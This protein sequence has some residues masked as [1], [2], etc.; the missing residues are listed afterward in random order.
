VWHRVACQKTARSFRRT[1]LVSD[2]NLGRRIKRRNRSS[3]GSR[4]LVLGREIS[5]QTRINSKRQTQLALAD[6]T[7]GV[8]SY[9]VWGMLGWQD[10]KQRYR[11]SV[12]GPFWLT[13]S[14]A[15]MVVALG[16]VYAAIFRMPLQ[17]YLPFLAI[18]L[19]LWTL[20]SSVITEGCQAFIS[21]EAMI[22]QMRLPFTAH[23]CRTVWRNIIIM[24]HNF[25]IVLLVLVVFGIVPSPL[26]LTLLIA[27]LA[28]LV[29]NGLWAALSLGLICARYRDV[30]PIVGTL[31]QVLFF[32]TPI[33]WHPSLL[34][35]RQRIV[36]WNPLHHFFEVTRA[37]LLGELPSPIS[38]AVV[39]AVTLL[40]SLCT[41]MLFRK[42]RGRIAYWV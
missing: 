5:L 9:N 39:V 33:L 28:I 24:G 14:T 11:R 30:P 38:W 16:F 3:K 41:F 42:Y 31:L 32:L 13:L 17:H 12:L 7:Q 27:A 34:P 15:G 1:S 20:I 19:V 40:G 29:L 18:G 26:M 8:R 10:I 4:A 6:I 23:A 25:I 37:P 36:D 22:K 21:A 2:S 35:G